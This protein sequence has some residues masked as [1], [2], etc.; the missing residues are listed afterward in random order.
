MLTP[1]LH[2]C[3]YATVGALVEARP[4]CDVNDVYDLA[5]ANC[6]L[7]DDSGAFCRSCDLCQPNPNCDVA[8]IVTTG[9]RLC[10]FVDDGDNEGGGGGGGGSGFCFSK[11]VTVQTHK[12]PVTMQDLQIGDRVL[13]A[14][15]TYETVYAFGH[16]HP[17]QPAEF[18]QL[19]HSLGN[20][21]NDN[22]IKALEVTADHLI[23]LRGK[24]A[25]VPA[26]NIQ[27]GDILRTGNAE[28]TA[29]VTQ[30]TKVHRDGIYAPLT[31]LSGT[32]VVDGVVASSYITLDATNPNKQQL[33]NDHQLIH[34]AL[35]PYRLLCSGVSRTFCDTRFYMD[36]GMPHY[37]HFGM[38]LLNWLL[39]SHWIITQWI[40]LSVIILVAGAFQLLELT[41]GASLAPLMVLLVA[42][43][44]HRHKTS[45][46]KEV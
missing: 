32:L 37:A 20:S 4:S 15:G 29:V 30:I 46:K 36:N 9:C 22:N 6:L 13:T 42:A 23:F 44:Y 38:Q 34:M 7:L 31:T 40:G 14:T 17:S 18:L 28:E 1:F 8:A 27:V 5:C 10:G 12:G 26:Q 2:S 35:S 39:G 41:V 24:A 16:Y 25:P 21:N 45:K 11:V 19:H 43:I 3:W 33:L